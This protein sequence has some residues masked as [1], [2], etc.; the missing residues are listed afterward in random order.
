MS[1][2][3]YE[4]TMIKMLSDISEEL[5]KSNSLKQLEAIPKLN[6]IKVIYDYSIKHM[7]CGLNLKILNQTFI[8]NKKELYI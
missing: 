3:D 6:P 5:R 8:L 7:C 4:K 2:S 1:M